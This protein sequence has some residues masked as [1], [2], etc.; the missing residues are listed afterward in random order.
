MSPVEVVQCLFVLAC[1]AP[2]LIVITHVTIVRASAVSPLFTLRNKRVWSA[3]ATILHEVH[4]RV[5]QFWLFLNLLQYS[6]WT[7]IMR[8]PSRARA[9]LC[10]TSH[11]PHHASVL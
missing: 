1:T 7:K 11:I 5:V 3:V 6:T 8:I 10:I 9:T 4:K 2:N